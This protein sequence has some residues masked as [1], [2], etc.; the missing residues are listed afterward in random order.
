MGESLKTRKITRAKIKMANN[1]I[2][3][4]GCKGSNAGINRNN[5]GLVLVR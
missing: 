3:I 2:S 5:T 4:K 1:I